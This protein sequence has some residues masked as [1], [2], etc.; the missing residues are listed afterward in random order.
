MRLLCS[1]QV[2]SASSAVVAAR[3]RVRSRSCLCD[4]APCC[5]TD[6][7]HAID[8]SEER[9]FQGEEALPQVH[10]GPGR[11]AGRC[12]RHARGSTTC[13]STSTGSLCLARRGIHP[14]PASL[15]PSLAL[16]LRLSVSALMDH[17]V[18]ST[19][20]TAATQMSPR[21]TE[22]RSPSLTAGAPRS[23]MR[24]GWCLA[25]DERHLLSPALSGVSSPFGRAQ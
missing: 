14:S 1:W 13:C 20:R 6:A 2:S 12:L 5:C 7:T 10:L 22:R 11:G 16:P 24:T 15:R 17:A 8:C 25:L 9:V 21:M 4:T 3:V 23:T 18:P 19:R